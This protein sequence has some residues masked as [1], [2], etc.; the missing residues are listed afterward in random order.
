M[1]GFEREVSNDSQ[2]IYG[3]RLCGKTHQRKGSAVPIDQDLKQAYNKPAKSCSGIV[4]ISRQKE[5]VCRWN[6]I[7]HEKGK[8]KSFL[9]DL[10]FLKEDNEYELHHEFSPSRSEN[11]TKCVDAIVEYVDRYNNPFDLNKTCSL[12]NIVTNSELDVEASIFLRVISEVRRGSLSNFLQNTA[13]G[14]ICKVISRHS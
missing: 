8:F 3:R 10:C 14:H 4:G 2:V 1:L 5:A 7:K 13:C 11:D 9:Q 12:R 6:I